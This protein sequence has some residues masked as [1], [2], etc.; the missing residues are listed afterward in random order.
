MHNE[1]FDPRIIDDDNYDDMPDLCDNPNTKNVKES[2][3]VIDNDAQE[4]KNADERKIDDD[5]WE[6]VL[7][8]GRLKK[9]IIKEGNVEKGK[10]SR[11]ARCI[12]NIVEKLPSGE[13]VREENDFEFHVGECE[14]L[15]GV[16]LVIPLMFPGEQSYVKLD[17]SFGYGSIGDGDKI[18]GGSDLELELELKDWSLLDAPPDLP[19]DMR[20]SIGVRKRERGNRHFSRGDYSNAIQ[21]YR[22]AAEYLDDKQIED[23]MEVPIDR[24]LLPKD[25]QAMLE[26]RVKT[27]NNMAQAQMKLAAWES[28]LASIRQVLKI[29][30]NNEKALFRKSKILIE[31]C[32][33]DEAIGILRRV[34]RLYPLNKQCQAEL[35][36]LTGKVKAGKEKEQ[37]MSR[38]MLGLDKIPVKLD[39]SVT[40]HSKR[41]KIVLA[42]LGGVGALAATYLLKH[43]DVL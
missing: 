40:L 30:P 17:N 21:C 12:I 7:G 23:D 33:L 42:A 19:R 20:M 8:S 22:K 34:N 9:K 16:D 11:G 13:I 29:E 24:F 37:V 38:K 35:T 2:E 31:K 6:D 27:F 5:G 18:P 15:Q 1:D 26:E 28:A 32:Q 3:P 36:K 14:F 25:L 43:F 4:K 10:P 41:Y 39:D